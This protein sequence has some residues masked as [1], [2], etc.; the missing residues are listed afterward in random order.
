MSD[1]NKKLYTKQ[2][3]N[4]CLTYAGGVLVSEVDL[5]T[6]VYVLLGPQKQRSRAIGTSRTILIREVSLFQRL[7]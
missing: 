1:N 6:K 7:I 3:T 5:Y 2:A 4:D